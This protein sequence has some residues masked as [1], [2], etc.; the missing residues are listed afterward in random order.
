MIDLKPC[1]FCG[2]KGTLR[3]MRF[4]MEPEPRYAVTCTACA[5][6]IGWEFTEDEAAERWNRRAGDD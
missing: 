5:I 1:Q 6:A 4:G 2:H 3:S